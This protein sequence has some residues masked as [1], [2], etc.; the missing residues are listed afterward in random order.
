M[1]L[2]ELTVLYDLPIDVGDFDGSGVTIHA[3]GIGVLGLTDILASG[4]TGLQS[5]G[6]V[7]SGVWHGAPSVTLINTPGGP[8]YAGG[9]PLPDFVDFPLTIV[10]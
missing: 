10:P 4:G 1:S 3:T 5:V 9:T 2:D 7:N 8:T 6:T